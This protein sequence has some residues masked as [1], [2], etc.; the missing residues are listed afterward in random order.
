MPIGG[1]GE[2]DA[3]DAVGTP[4]AVSPENMACGRELARPVTISE[5]KMPMDSTEAEFMKVATMPPAAPRASA[6]TEFII[7]AR[8]GEANRPVP[9]PLNPMMI[10]NSQYGKF[11][12]MKDRQRKVA[13]SSSE[14]PTVNT[15]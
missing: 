1:R 9:N 10:A 7:S 4:W 11:T 13:A 14:P 6:G 2:M 12:G 5:K 8:L 15:L 3:A